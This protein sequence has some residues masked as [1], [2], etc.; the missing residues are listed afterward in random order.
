MRSRLLQLVLVPR[1]LQ[2]C[3]QDQQLAK[4]TQGVEERQ[5]GERGV[6]SKGACTE[7]HVQW[8]VQAWPQPG[9]PAGATADDRP[10][11]TGRKPRRSSQRSASLIAKGEEGRG[12]RGS[13]KRGD[14]NGAAGGRPPQLAR[15]Y[16]SLGH[17]SAVAAAA[18]AAATTGAAGPA[19]R[20]RS[21]S[22]E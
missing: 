13:V 15:M 4:P 9:P 21:C 18:A 7:K 16:H 12:R 1:C 19:S 6:G 10:A 8:Q 2:A 5:Q 14:E 22:P 20:S 11:V 17:S 3:Q